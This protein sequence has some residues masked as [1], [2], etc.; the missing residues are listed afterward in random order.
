E[1]GRH[2]APKSS[3]VPPVVTQ[4]AA[5]ELGKKVFAT[6]ACG[7][8]HTLKDADAAGTVGPNL[9]TA[10]PTRALVV[11]RVT[12]GKGAMPAFKDSLTPDQIRNVADYVSSVAGR[13]T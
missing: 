8:C 10:K 4:P 7:S 6:A 9:D 11:A 2:T 12:N 13:S 5:N 3:S 1:L